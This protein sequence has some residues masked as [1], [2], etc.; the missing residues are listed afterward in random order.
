MAFH[1]VRADGVIV[2]R[3]KRADGTYGTKSRHPDT[4]QHWADGA[5]ADAWGEWMEDLE[6][7]GLAPDYSRKRK[8]EPEPEPAPE[9]DDI[10]VNEWFARWWEGLDVGLRSRGNYA[11]LFRAHV[12]PEWG[13]WKLKDIK[14]SDVN[15]WEQRMIKAG[16][17]RDGVAGG[18]R[19]RLATLL[20]DAVIE[21]LIDANPA[22][23]QRHRG[24]RSGVGTAGRGSEKSAITP[25]EALVL[26]ERM[27]VLSGRDDEFIFGVTVAWGALRY[28]EG[29]GLQRGLVKLGRIRVDWQLIEDGGKFYL[30]PPKDDSNRDVDIPPFL[31][32]L[33]NRQIAAHPDQRCRCKPVT[34]E[35]QKE[36]PCQGG[37]GFVFLGDRGGHLRNSNFARRVF[38]PAADG[39]YPTSKGRR[40]TAANREEDRKEGKDCSRYRPVL[41]ELDTSWPGSPLPAW[42]AAVA[43]QPYEPQRVRGYQRRP[44]NLG[45]NAASS[46]ADLVAFA[47]AQGIPD[48]QAHD[49]TRDAILDLFV[50]SR[51]VSEHAPVASWVPIMEGL[52]PHGLRHAHSTWLMDLGTPLQLRDDRMGHASPEMRGMRGT[53][54]HVSRESRAWL[55]EQLE[56]LW[57][58]AL[59][60]RAWFGLRSPVAVLDELLA[61]FRD[62]EREPIAPFDARGEVLEFPTSRAG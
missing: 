43:G 9:D 32:S 11:Y 54:T 4:N 62:G 6:R 41:V 49:L 5:A 8:K 33:L 38:D 61:P 10:T 22:L 31:Q 17:A 60:R 27:G 59:A 1:Q 15:A 53:Y 18:A 45:I 48:G 14:A 3:W 40:G 46:R 7:R 51:Y 35:G 36:Q 26:S 52:T 2:A 19:T 55:R 30:G 23:R 39:W 37:G 58:D 57:Q 13:H 20:G 56:R 34:I 28:G 16:Y 44:L 47:I 12:L 50:R 25:F 29:I 42:P 21:K 24:R